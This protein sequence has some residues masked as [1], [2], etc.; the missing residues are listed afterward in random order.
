[1]REEGTT[2]RRERGRGQIIEL[3]DG[4]FHI[5]WFAGIV[6]GTRKCAGKNVVGSRHD[7]EAELARI[8]AERASSER[9]GA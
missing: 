9:S 8:I 5:R 7:A 6:D 4:S 3:A 1:M 2:A